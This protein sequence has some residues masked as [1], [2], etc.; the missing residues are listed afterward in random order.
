MSD[1]TW[2]KVDKSNADS[3]AAQLKLIIERQ[4][5][6]VLSTRAQSAGSPRYNPFSREIGNVLRIHIERK[7]PTGFAFMVLTR[8]GI[9]ICLNGP[10]FGGIAEK[11]VVP[12]V[13]AAA[14]PDVPS[15]IFIHLLANC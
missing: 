14:G 2:E 10:S 7:G 8:E 12:P 4:E 11:P 9:T 5:V 1:F 6:Q 3:V 13:C 15:N